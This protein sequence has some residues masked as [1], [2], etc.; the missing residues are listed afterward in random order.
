MRPSG[1]IFTAVNIC[2]AT[3]IGL[4]HQPKVEPQKY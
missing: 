1:E 2:E 3:D 4:A